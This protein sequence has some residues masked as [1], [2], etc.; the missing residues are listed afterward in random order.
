MAEDKQLLISAITAEH[1]AMQGALNN[2]VNEGN[3]R[4]SMYLA[5]LSGALVAMGFATQAE[6]IFLPF[7]ATVMPAVF[8]MGVLTVLRLV[9]ISVE[10]AMADIAIARVR[11]SYRA[12]GSEA[13]DAFKEEMGRWPEGHWNP[14]LRLGPFL[15]YW[16]SAAAMI[17]AIDAFV[18]GAAVTLIL[19]LGLGW[20]LWLALAIGAALIVGLL[21]VFHQYQKIRIAENDR[22]AREVAGIVPS[23]DAGPPGQQS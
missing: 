6:S 23:Y 11:K 8:L 5:V 20:H 10:S 4:S 15:G 16:T 14:A 19:H 2:A 9:D 17:A 7:V 21:M 18:G 22:Y 12:L 13:A 1:F 3:S